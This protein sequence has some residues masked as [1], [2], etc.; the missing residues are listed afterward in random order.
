MKDRYLYKAKRIDTGEWV[1]GNLIVNELDAREYFIG[2][3]F[4]MADG[5]PHDLDV[6]RVEPSTICQCTG[7]KDKD[8]RLIWENDIVELCINDYSWGAII[9]FGNPNAEYTWG[10]ALKPIGRCKANTDILLWIGMEDVGAFC[11][12]VGNR[13]DNPELLKSEG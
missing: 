2:Y 1:D 6:C 9:C 7:L 11:E 5:K 13:F 4:G 3:I 12:I 8:G 10:W